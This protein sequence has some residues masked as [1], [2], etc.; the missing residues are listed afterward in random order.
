MW[1]HNL[2]TMKRTLN[3]TI[4]RSKSEKNDEHYTQLADI[5]NEVRHYPLQSIG[6]EPPYKLE[7]D[8]FGRL[9]S[10]SGPLADFFRLRFS[11]KYCDPETGL[12]YYGE[13]FY[14][15][16]WRIWLSRDP[17]EEEGFYNLYTFCANVP[18]DDVDVVGA[19][20]YKGK[21]N[22]VDF[23][24]EF[25]VSKCEVAIIYGHGHKSLPHKISF[26][27]RTT[28]SAYFCGCWPDITNRSIPKGNRLVEDVGQHNTMYDDAVF[29]QL[30]ALREAAIRQAKE[31][32]KTGCCKDGVWIR[33]QFSPSDNIG[34]R[35]LDWLKGNTSRNKPS[36]LVGGG[37]WEGDTHVK[38][39]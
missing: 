11:T 3:T 25:V 18:I 24:Y 34:V 37:I 8:D 19:V 23:C 13:R 1:N 2:S 35:I 6:N 16:Y 28:S 29:E 9:I 21:S 12:Y 33:Y 22:T 17:I 7:Y 27:D 14:S 4:N 36:K 31:I 20:K 10:Q 26:E 15:P 38:C 30:K 39:K 32:C 5:E